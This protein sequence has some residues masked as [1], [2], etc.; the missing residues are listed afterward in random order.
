MVS[1]VGSV[2]A[3]PGCRLDPRLAH[4]VKDPALL[5]L[6]LGSDPWPGISICSIPPKL[7]QSKIR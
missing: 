2:C 6:R 4:W 3:A 5:P 7:M 1:G